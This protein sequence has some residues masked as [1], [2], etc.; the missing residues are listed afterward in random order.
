MILTARSTIL[1][2]YYSPPRTVPVAKI[3]LAHAA[4]FLLPTVYFCTIRPLTEDLASGLLLGLNNRFWVYLTLAM[5]TAQ[6]SPQVVVMR[7][8]AGSPRSL[9]L[10]TLS[11]QSI[12]LVIIALRWLFRFGSPDWSYFALD[13]NGS[14]SVCM[15]VWRGAVM[16]Y[17]WGFVPFNYLI[18]GCGTM[19]LVALY[20][21]R[22]I[23]DDYMIGGAAAAEAEKEPLLSG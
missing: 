19:L 11:L 2:S 8:M 9:S 14:A 12:F 13:A 21:M 3:A 10:S 6:I 16:L 20:H 5:V 7:R 1:Y 4:T 23:E 22:R 17:H 18:D 15:R